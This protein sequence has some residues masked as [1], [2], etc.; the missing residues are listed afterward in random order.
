MDITKK[1]IVKMS[2]PT[3][4][5][6]SSTILVGVLSLL[7]I[8]RIDGYSIAIAA[9][10][11]VILL[12][13]GSV[14]NGLGY[15]V[16]FI[17]AQAFGKGDTNELGDIL[18]KSLTSSIIYGFVIVIFALLL[19]E[20]IFSLMG[21]SDEI[22]QH[23][24]HYM[25]IRVVALCFVVVS[26]VLI[27]YLR[28][29][30]D[31]KMPM[32][33]LVISNAISI[34]LAFLL[35]FGHIGF[36]ELGLIGVAIAFFVAECI[37]MLMLLVITIKRESIS[38]G[39]II[40]VKLR[41]LGYL[42]KEGLKIGFEDFGINVTMIFFIAFATRLGVTEVASSEIALNI[43]Q[44]AY[45]PGYAFGITGTVL[46][47]Q[48]FGAKD[49]AHS[50][51]S[52]R[53]LALK[54]LISSLFFMVPISLICF[55]FP[56]QLVTL[57]AIG[58][59]DIHRYATLAIRLA[60]LFLVFDGLQLV[61]SGV[62]RGVGDNTFLMVS[63]LILGCLFFVPFCFFVTFVLNLGFVGI[64]LSFYIYILFL[65]ICLALR[66]KKIFK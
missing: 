7:I 49:K 23:G 1:N 65:F 32:Q 22:I 43:L 14:L 25:S 54:I 15:A 31:T 57:F 26:K 2:L 19:P 30:G 6:L 55:L 56:N 64:W 42:N 53:N 41:H 29:V 48:A 5:A 59:V 63:S 40:S 34:V 61:L 18:H 12:N 28:G 44:L 36:P 45:L 60:S 20:T 46:V 27:G 52:H 58:E 4:I 21:A 35:A 11:S 62:L 47:G 16:N 39:R 33:A 51:R 37:Q 13:V 66:T 9:I 17:I 50:Q 3:M 24:V 38:L 10:T 8:S